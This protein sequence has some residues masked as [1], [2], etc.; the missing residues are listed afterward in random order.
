MWQELGGTLGAA[1]AL[2]LIIEGVIPFLNPSALRNALMRMIRMDDRTLR[3]AGLTSMLA[4]L[5]LLYIV[6]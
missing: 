4:G 2:M 3:F 5:I 6:R 1:L